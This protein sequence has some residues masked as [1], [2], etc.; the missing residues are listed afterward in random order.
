[1]SNILNV[2]VYIERDDVLSERSII[3]REERNS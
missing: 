2:A 3:M 1:M